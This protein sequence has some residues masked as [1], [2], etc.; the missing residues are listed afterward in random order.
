MPALIGIARSRGVSGYLGDRV[1][2]WPAVHRL[3]AARLFRLALEKAPAGTI[4]HG[5]AE[6]GV[7][8]RDIAQVIGRQLDLPVA[9]ISQDDAAEPA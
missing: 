5:V 3:D 1:N 4:L 2:H 6:Q 8:I 9:S 7:L